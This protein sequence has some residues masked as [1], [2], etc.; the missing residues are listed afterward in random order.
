MKIRD[1]DLK[2]MVDVR[3]SQC[4][5]RMCYWPRQNPGSFT[6]GRGYS[7]PTKDWICGTRA[8]HGC[9]TEGELEEAKP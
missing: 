2:V 9:P 1:K 4:L 3:Q 6:Q 5:K 8:I 7:K